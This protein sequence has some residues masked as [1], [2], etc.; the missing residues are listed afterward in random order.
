VGRSGTAMSMADEANT[1]NI[2]DYGDFRFVFEDPFRN[3][4]FRMFSPSAA[5]L[6]QGAVPWINDY[7]IKAAETFREIPDRFE[8][9]PP[10]RQV[11]LPYLVSAFKGSAG[12]TDLFVNYG[13]PILEF[14][15]QGS[16][17]NIT[18]NAGTFVIS[19]NRDILAERR[20]T[21]YGLRTDQIVTFEEANLWIDS[22]EVSVPPGKV[23]VSV[24]FETTSGAT[25]AVQRRSVD[26]PDFSSDELSV[27]DI[28]LAYR[29]E[30]TVDGRPLGGSDVVRNG[31]SIMPA[32]WSV[33]SRERPIYLYFEVYNLD[34]S[35]DGRANYEVEAA[36]VPK[37]KGSAVGRFVRGIFGGNDGGVSVKLPTS[38]ASRDDGQYLIL[39]AA[40]Q[41][42]GLFILHLRVKDLS[43]GK[44]VTE[45]RELFLE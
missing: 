44:E 27:S 28:L 8:Y 36:L 22:E 9:V 45:T 20:R 19:E 38:V 15:D 4:E 32:P 25:V 24:E 35:G 31:L 43:T 41:E 34:I 6:A 12:R 30:E 42:A 2:W 21:I 39:D 33:F 7:T 18:A 26:V 14:Q 17:I 37:K 5:D 11:D 3:G 29:I 10:G 13:V 1:F 23:D 16:M 40:N